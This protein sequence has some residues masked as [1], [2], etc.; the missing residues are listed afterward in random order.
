V[1][2]LNGFAGF[3]FGR[4]RAAWGLAYSFCHC[5]HSFFTLTGELTF[6]NGANIGIADK[7]ENAFE[8]S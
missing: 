6:L 3:P 5:L 2:E 7:T 8:S 4:R 1:K